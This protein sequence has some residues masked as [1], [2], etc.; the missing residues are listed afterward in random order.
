MPPENLPSPEKMPRLSDRAFQIV[1]HEIEQRYS[2]R[3][4]DQ[5]ERVILLA[6]LEALRAQKGEP[7][8][9]IQIWEVL[10]DIAPNFDQNILMDAASVD[11]DSPVLGLFVGVGAVTALVAT[12]I[13]MRSVTANTATE[14]AV[15]EPAVTESFGR[16]VI[17]T[18]EP[19]QAPTGA[20][21]RI[22]ENI[23]ENVER[24]FWPSSWNPLKEK[25][26]RPANKPTR[27]QRSVPILRRGAQRRLQG[28]SQSRSHSATFEMARGI[29]WQAALKSQNPPHSAEHWADTARLWKLAIAHLEQ[30]PSSHADYPTAQQ[31]KAVYRQ[32][33]Q[34]IQSR[35]VSAQTASSASQ[36]AASVPAPTVPSA[37]QF[38]KQP[39]Q[40]I[41]ENPIA[42]AKHYGWQAAV[43][44]QNAPHSAEKWADISRTWQAALAS[45][46]SIDAAHPDYAAAQQVKARYQQ[47]LAAIRD[48]YQQEQNATQRLQ[49]LQATLAEIN[50]DITPN[51][52][53]Y[54]QLEAIVKKLESIPKSTEAGQRAQ[55]LVAETTDVMDAI[56]TNPL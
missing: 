7:M 38:S 46:S 41:L 39:P 53:Q 10:S 22:D 51:A 26:F 13:G 44:S 20:E 14:P 31:K 6:R 35:Q 32:Y 5:I 33:L 17:T 30:V 49:S 47:N 24:P 21:Q 16:E 54:G 48:R 50:N 9:R 56:A 25:F 2:D 15:T 27:K 34:E 28:Q 23:E 1:K 11:K 4:A 36:V 3:A 55:R 40:Q 19:A 43:A 42:M 45:L 12:A 29:G 18:E 8:T 52:A 37:P